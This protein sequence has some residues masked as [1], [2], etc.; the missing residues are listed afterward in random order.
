MLHGMA[1]GNE[2]RCLSGSRPKIRVGGKGWTAHLGEPVRLPYVGIGW[3]F[4]SGSTWQK[5]AEPTSDTCAYD[6]VDL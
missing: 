5:C 3:I 2:S 6:L 4:S 1:Q